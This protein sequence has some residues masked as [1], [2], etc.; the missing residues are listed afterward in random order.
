MKRYTST[1]NAFMTFFFMFILTNTYSQY[2]FQG[3][4]LPKKISLHPY[5]TITDVGQKDLDI[6]FIVTSYEQL[7]PVAL[8]TAND[9]LGFTQNNFWAKLALQ[10][11]TDSE[12]NYYL[13][14]A[15]PI[16]DLAE[17][18]IIDEVSGVIIKSAFF[19]IA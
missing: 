1:R 11:P 4:A 8:K 14:T 5:T 10:N 18:Y 3:D 6:Q 7:N 15:L 16:T 17:L 13:E 19:L 2:V 9:D 12:L